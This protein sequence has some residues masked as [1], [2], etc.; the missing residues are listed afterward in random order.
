MKKLINSYIIT[1]V[2]CFMLFIFEP[3]LM[4]ATNINDFWFDFYI[5]IGPVLIVFLGFFLGICLIWT[6]LYG[7]SKLIWKNDLIYKI[8]LIIFF[9]VFLVTYIQGNY[10]SGS[11]PSL[12]GSSI[13]WSVFT[14]NNIVTLIIWLIC[15]GFFI[16]GFRKFKVDKLFS[17][18]TYFSLAIFGMLVVSFVSTFLT[19]DVL[20]KKD[21]LI[22]SNNFNNISINK[23]FLI[24][25]VDAVDSRTFAE[26]LKDK[27]EYKD[28][29]DGFTY[30]KDALSA[31]PFTRDSIPFILS[32]IWNKNEDCFT[33]Y[34]NKALNNSSF[35][36]KLDQEK[37]DIN[38]YDAELVW[39]NKRNYDVKNIGSFSNS[40]VNLLSFFK[41]EMKYIM[42]KYLPYMLKPL[43]K[44]EWM[45]F[46]L[47]VDKYRWDLD[48]NY[49]RITNNKLIK[50]DN[51]YFQFI[52]T[53]GAH[54]PFDYD[55]ELKH[56][57]EGSYEDKIGATIKLIDSY[58]NRLKE[59]DVFD[60]SV[61][62]IMADHGY[63]GANR[64]NPIVLIKGIDDKG[65]L[66]ESD[67]PISFDDL[68]EGF[69]QL[70]DG[71]KSDELFGDIEKKRERKFISYEY[72]Q[73]DH[74]VEYKTKGKAYE[75]D[76]FEKTGEVFDR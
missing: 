44:I 21:G 76:K 65:E 57:E 7:I 73:E 15:L 49:Q 54:V 13:D 12:D 38:L 69:K 35:L 50:N 5:M 11:L 2:L 63:G 58:L 51:N 6:I 20:E 27:E 26:V 45:N 52:H 62:V 34:S 4:Y 36:E 9:F 22:T 41:Q 55:S 3:I 31:Y 17:Y 60:N 1:F 71:K 29:F 42:F 37:Y 28:T 23:N 14:T 64:F 40:N 72:T 74:M 75:V 18:C 39:N 30:Y 56:I 43:S 8:L 47:C 19:T 25:L 59:N 48:E 46:D 70:L 53:E 16:W 68:Q 66:K 10:L 67:I 33:D 24:F 61:I 32:G